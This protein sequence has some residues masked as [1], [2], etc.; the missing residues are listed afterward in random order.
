MAENITVNDVTYP[1]VAAVN[2]VNEEG[3]EVTYYPDAVR[4]NEQTLTDEQKEQARS[5]IG[6]APQSEVDTL[7]EEIADLTEEIAFLKAVTGDVDVVGTFDENNVVTLNTNLEDGTYEF[8]FFNRDEFVEVVTLVVGAGDP[9]EP[10]T[11]DIPNPPDTTLVWEVGT[12]IDTST[13]AETT[14]QSVYSASNYIEIVDGYTYTFRKNDTSATG[15]GFS[16][17][18]AYYDEN[19]NFISATADNVI[20]EVTAATS[21]E[22]PLNVSGAKYFR[23]RVYF[24]VTKWDDALFSLTA[25][26]SA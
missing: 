5:N 17:K 9:E 8:K 20:G 1:E 26:V 16:L 12:K 18:V 25:E 4:Y 15:S 21:A 22:I 6:A 11:P 14:G 3:E 7:S 13:G 23:L 10:D 19:K 24:A 2:M